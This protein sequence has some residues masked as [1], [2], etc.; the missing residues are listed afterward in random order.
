LEFTLLEIAAFVVTVIAAV[1][2]GIQVT[3][4]VTEWISRPPPKITTDTFNSDTLHEAV[5]VVGV[6]PYAPLIVGDEPNQM[7]GPWIEIAKFIAERL[8]RRLILKWF[9]MGDLA[10][11][12]PTRIDVSVGIFRTERRSTRY[13]FSR[14]IHRIGLQGIVLKS[15]PRIEQ[16]AL[17]TQKIRTVVQAGE[18]GWEYALDEMRDA[19]DGKSVIV[20]DTAFANHAIEMVKN[21]SADLALIDELSCVNFLRQQGNRS[22]FRLAFD[23]PLQLFDACV[24]IDNRCDIDLK[25][26]NEAIE[27]FRNSEAYLAIETEA[28][29]KYQGVIGRVGLVS[30][31]NHRD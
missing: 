18:V 13:K 17:S 4:I 3:P 24:A 16:E 1:L 22:K 29:E 31:T 19:L 8:N 9:T 28:L 7:A 23:R 25:W 14:P 11:M 27:E 10:T 5:L 20:I 30:P 15:S 6:Y 21:A 26:L 2:A 12:E